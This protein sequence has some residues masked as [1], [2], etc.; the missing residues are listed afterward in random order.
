MRNRRFHIGLALLFILSFVMYNWV[1]D[2]VIVIQRDTA[3]C[4][5]MCGRKFFVEF[6]DHPGGLLSYASRFFMQFYHF[7]W[8]GVLIISAFITCF[9]ALF[10]LVLTRLRRTACVF[11]TFVP[12]ILLLAL[13]SHVLD[14]TI[15]LV[16]TCGVSLGYLSLPRRPSRQVYALLATPVLYLVAG[17]YF[18]LFAVWIAASEWFDTPLSSNLPFKLLYPA[19]AVC[20]PFAAYRWLFPI[21][22]RSALTHP[23]VLALPYPPSALAY[24]SVLA[25]SYPLVTIVLFAYLLTMPFWARISW[26]TRL[27]SFC[28]SR[29]GRAV[30]A[31]VLLVL[32]VFL[33]CAWYSSY[34]NQVAEYGELYKRRQWDAILDRAKRDR[35]Q[36]LM[37]QFFTNYALYHKGELLEEMFNYPQGWGTRG[38]VLDISDQGY[39]DL[40]RAMYTS[41]LFFEMGHMNAAFREAHNHMSAGGKTYENLKRIAECNMVNGNY[42]I[43]D[44]YL[45]LL[46]R[47]LFHKE[48]ARH[49]KGIIADRH[50]A[51][52]HFA[53][54][55]QLPTVEFS[56]VLGSFVPLMSLLISDAENRMACD[57][58][59]AWRLLDQASIA[60]VVENSH[61]LAEA[62]YTSLPRHCQEAFM[63][64]EK[65][66]GTPVDTEGFTY[67]ANIA[68]RF[69]T[70]VEQVSWYPNKRV[71]QRELRSA[72]GGTYMYYYVFVRPPV[73]WD[74]TSA[75]WS[76]GNALCSQGRVDDAVSEYR[77]ALRINPEFAEGYTSLGNALYSQGKLEEA[78]VQ[79]REALRITPDS[80]EARQN[81]DRITRLPTD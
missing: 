43:A 63:V 59:T 66:S 37:T 55:K 47:T 41:D 76:L 78:A 33:P 23:S 67:D 60:L 79:Y 38:L 48:F 54:L 26:G 51:D 40:P 42:D 17:G 19:L 1:F 36:Q 70:F 46:E 21:S 7:K 69:N 25:L 15:G 73:R 3:S 58:L 50:A 35:P 77:Q 4:F 74:Y 14:A 44:K 8:L 13:H 28:G 52:R 31:A 10:H 65:R 72:F 11:C 71:A 9:A 29:R 56:P 32:A 53:K 20:V 64:W 12:C 22:L 57:Y 80:D 5:F 49:Y 61:Y 18:W 81:L 34:D 30:E 27:K 75:H 24:P 2:Y 6:L 68:L 16:A 45:S 62:G 39:S